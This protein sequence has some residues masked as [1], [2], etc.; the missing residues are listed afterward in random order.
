MFRAGCIMHLFMRK[1]LIAMV[2]LVVVLIIVVL[3]MTKYATAPENT[4]TL[5]SPSAQQ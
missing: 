3:V 5:P 1:I 2:V 4:S